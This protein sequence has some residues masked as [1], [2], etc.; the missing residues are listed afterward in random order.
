[1]LNDLLKQVL[2]E[3]DPANTSCK[4]NECENE[5][6]MVVDACYDNDLTP[7]EVIESV[8]EYISEY[9]LVDIPETTKEDILSA[10]IDKTQ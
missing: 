5:Y 3:V 8:A 7:F 4:E 6:D 9:Y 10:W 1:M 2:Y